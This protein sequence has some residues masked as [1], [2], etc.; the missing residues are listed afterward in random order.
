MGKGFIK[1]LNILNLIFL[2]MLSFALSSNIL[3]ANTLTVDDIEKQIIMTVTNELKLKGY[4]DVN[5]SVLNMPIL[6]LYSK[7]GVYKV[8]VSKGNNGLNQREFR[9]V[10]ILKNGMPV[11]TF[12]VPLEIK[13]YKYVLC[14]NDTIRKE[15]PI[16]YN[17]VYV[18]RVNVSK[19]QDNVLDK[20]SLNGEIIANKMFRRDEILD[21]RFVKYKPDISK[22]DKIEVI[23]KNSNGLFI[24]VD[25]IALTNG[26]IGDLVNVKNSVYN[27]IYTGKVVSKNRVQ[28]EI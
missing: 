9:Q 10:R 1:K 5:V 12:G 24:S 17:N 8:V 14:A 23:F 22:N 19:F 3:F 13:A 25:A 11:K 20:K 21:K 27:K 2:M 18:K 4:E 26:N 7:N 15:S 16:S 28:I 6:S